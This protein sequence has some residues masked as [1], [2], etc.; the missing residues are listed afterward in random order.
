MVFPGFSRLVQELGL[1]VR[2]GTRVI[3]KD[4]GSLERKRYLRTD[5]TDHDTIKILKIASSSQKLALYNERQSKDMSFSEKIAQEICSGWFLRPLFQ[6]LTP[7][8]GGRQK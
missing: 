5:M 4:L 1:W 2:P 6:L 8:V 3:F 7:S